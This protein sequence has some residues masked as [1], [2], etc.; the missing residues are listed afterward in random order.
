MISRVLSPAVSHPRSVLR[1]A[2]PARPLVGLQRRRAAGAAAR[3]CRPAPHQSAAPARLGRPSGSCCA[4]APAT[5]TAGAPARYPRHRPAVA[6][7]PGDKKVDLPA[8][9]TAAGQR[10]D[11]RADRAA[12]H[13]EQR[14]EVPADPRRT[15]QA[16]P[17]D[18]RIHDPP[19]T[20]GP[21]H[22]AGAEA[23]HRYNL[24]AVPACPGRDHARRGRLPHGLHGDPAAPVLPVRDRGRLT[25]HTHPRRD[26]ATRTGRGLPSRSATS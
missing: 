24:A 1:L 3:S 8:D 18:R 25:L 10:R 5:A 15:A 26:R 21:A 17:P 20:Q 6:S 13:R 16:R 19:N 14:L 12:R 9:G 2:C 11:R 23:A 7:P 4:E 22:P